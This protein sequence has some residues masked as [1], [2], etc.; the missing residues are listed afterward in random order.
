MEYWQRRYV[1]EN[2]AFVMPAGLVVVDLP[3][4]GL[5]GGVELAVTALCN[6][7]NPC[8]NTW[9]HDCL[10]KV[11]VVVNGSQVVKSLTGSQILA[12]NMYDGTY[13]RQQAPR[14]YFNT[15]H[16]ET[17]YLN[18][19]RFYHDKQFMLDLGQVNDPE[20]RITFNFGL[21]NHHGWLLGATF[22]TADYTVIPHLLRDSMVVPRGYI[23]SS[24]AY[25]FTSVPGLRQNMTLPRGPVY[26]G[27]YLESRY[28]GQGHGMNMDYVEV[29]INN[30]E[31]IP[32]RLEQGEFMTEM[33]RRYGIFEVTQLMIPG[34]AGQLAPPLEN[35]E[36]FESNYRNSDVIGCSE[37]AWGGFCTIEDHLIST[38]GAGAGNLIRWMHYKGVLPYNLAK[39]PFLDSM[40]EAQWLESRDLGDLWLR[41]EEAA[42]AGALATIILLADEV[43]TAYL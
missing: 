3:N 43:V 29:N 18:F 12:M 20:L 22:G 34:N 17:F 42:A 36:I 38:Y 15:S 25:R 23:K 14:L 6:S 8:P 26:N 39:V 24:E 37:P 4:K 27:F 1:E 35:C 21:G 41:Y 31:K 7:A 33:K 11:E 40:D 9:I 13:D 28:S 32:F 5:C 19:G 30:G 10:E 2:R 16:H